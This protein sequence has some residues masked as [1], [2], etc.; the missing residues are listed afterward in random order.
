[1]YRSGAYKTSVLPMM[2]WIYKAKG[3][4]IVKPYLHTEYRGVNMEKLYV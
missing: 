4:N 1:M 2:S 3:L